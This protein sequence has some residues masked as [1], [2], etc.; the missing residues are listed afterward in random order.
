[1]KKFRND[2][3]LSDWVALILSICKGQYYYNKLRENKK[4]LSQNDGIQILNNQMKLLKM[5]YNIFK[6][7]TNNQFE[8]FTY[9]KNIQLN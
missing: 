5:R 4:K 3:L 2:L 8:N 7:I 6:N 9:L 1:M